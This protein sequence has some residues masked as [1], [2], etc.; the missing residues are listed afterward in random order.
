MLCARPYR[1]GVLEFGCQR[2][3]PCLKNKVRLW[4]GRMLLELKEHKDSAFVTLTYNE[5]NKPKD[6]SV[7]KKDLQDFLK[8]LRFRLGDRKIRY[9]GVG[10][11]GTQSWRPHYHL[12]IYGLSI[13]EGEEVKLA[14]NKGFVHMGCA[15]PKSMAYV[16]SY[17]LK[18]MTNKK[19]RRLEGRKEEFSLMSR[20]PAIGSGVVERIYKAYQ[21]IE[22]KEAIEALDWFGEGIRIDGS[23]Y[24]LGRTLRNKLQVKLG[25]DNEQKKA[26]N[27]SQMFKMYARKEGKTT[28]QYE[29]ERK[30]KVEQQEGRMFK[31]QEVI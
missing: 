9:F 23:K 5:E 20:K 19:D 14:W 13:F 22:G 10:E 2:C 17:V 27:R 21:T 15:E 4:V 16:C 18:N 8:R 30:A 28:V 29:M 24:A 31:K 1:K 26:H 25:L 12:I 11:Y 7:V 6:G 3:G